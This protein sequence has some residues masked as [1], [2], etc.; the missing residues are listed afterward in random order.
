MEINI[1]KAIEL[2]KK[3]DVT[4]YPTETAYALGCDA[5]NKDAI[6]NIFKL[7]RRILSKT[8][9][10]IA[11]SLEQALDYVEISEQAL[12]L[13]KKYWP[14]PLTIVLKAKKDLP[15]E[16]LN[17]NKELAIRVSSHKVPLELTKKLGR[18][19]VSTSANI[20]GGSTCYKIENVKEQLGED[21]FYIDGGE[22]EKNKPST[23][24]RVNENDIEVLRQGDI[25]I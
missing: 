21:I 12:V 7:K 18:P 4:V 23:V 13:A 16:I 5:T 15:K 20:A 3:G 19:I 25:K 24:V 8:S 2:L 6:A 10:I 1:S 9:P 14:G 17:E 22:L 11:S